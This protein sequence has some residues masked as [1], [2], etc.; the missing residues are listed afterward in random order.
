ML[1]DHFVW[2]ILINRVQEDMLKVEILNL[3]LFD[4]RVVNN[5]P[6]RDVLFGES[7]LVSQ[8]SHV[9]YGLDVFIDPFFNGFR[10]IVVLHHSQLMHLSGHL[11][12]IVVLVVSLIIVLRIDV[13]FFLFGGF[14]ILETVFVLLG[15]NVET[16]LLYC[17]E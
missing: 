13:R 14:T 2:R 16:G 17:R 8:N 4:V 11:P 7:L 12:F 10:L 3:V 15:L 1:E 9:K 6:Q 5:R